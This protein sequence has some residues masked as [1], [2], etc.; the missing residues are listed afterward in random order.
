MARDRS[1]SPRP[2]GL[3]WRDQHRAARASHRGQYPYC[4]RA[5]QT[6]PPPRHQQ[7]HARRIRVRPSWSGSAR[8]E[9]ARYPLIWL[10]KL[11]APTRV[12]AYRASPSTQK[13]PRAPPTPRPWDP[14]GLAGD[15]H[16]SA[17]KV[18]PSPCRRAH[19][20]PRRTTTVARTTGGID[21]VLDTVTMTL[22]WPRGTTAARLGCTDLLEQAH[23]HV[24]EHHTRSRGIA[25]KATPRARGRGG[26]QD[27]DRLEQVVVEDVGVGP[28]A[29]DAGIVAQTTGMPRDRLL[30]GQPCIR[31][32]WQVGRQVGNAMAGTLRCRCGARPRRRC[33]GGL[34][35][36]RM[37][38][39][40][41][42]LTGYR[43]A[44]PIGRRPTDPGPPS[45][46]PR[47]SMRPA[48]SR[49]AR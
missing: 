37:L 39:H 35:H 31:G 4:G 41:D 43:P 34:G 44:G 45:S 49:P 12:A 10:A 30:V 42:R 46:R 1:P 32:R 36:A 15:R 9:R 6:G 38:P 29:G 2:R 48:P 5:E 3:G 20:S 26:Q 27:V 47:C 28:A 24:H 19:W 33:E 14:V 13:L 40:G 11:A 16:S 18:P 22:R 7:R 8:P 23:H 21:G 25:V 17:W